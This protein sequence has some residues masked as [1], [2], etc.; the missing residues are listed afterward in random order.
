MEGLGKEL[1]LLIKIV[2]VIAVVLAPLEHVGVGV[3]G[4]GHAGDAM[5]EE[6]GSRTLVTT[7][8]GDFENAGDL[9]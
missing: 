9:L 6:L 4:G 3:L 1:L 7:L 5:G 8:N 2:V